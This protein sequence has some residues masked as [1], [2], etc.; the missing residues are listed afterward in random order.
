MLGLCWSSIVFYHWR[1][2]LETCLKTE[3]VLRH[4]SSE[5]KQ[6]H[7]VLFWRTETYF[8]FD[9]H[10]DTFES[11]DFSQS[12]NINNETLNHAVYTVIPLYTIIISGFSDKKNFTI[13]LFLR[14]NPGSRI[15]NPVDQLVQNL[16][17][18]IYDMQS[19]RSLNAYYCTD[20]KENTRSCQDMVL[21]Y[22]VLT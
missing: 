7:R 16:P 10:T 6:L 19:K 17:N 22:T 2:W 20:L 12:I 8:P 5:T 11:A 9:W 1:I 4:F 14:T 21:K 15:P 3:I 13:A 18:I